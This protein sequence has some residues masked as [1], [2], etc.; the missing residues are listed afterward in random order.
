MMGGLSLKLDLSAD[1]T[2][3]LTLID[4]MLWCS[5]IGPLGVTGLAMSYEIIFGSLLHDDQK[6]AVVESARRLSRRMSS[7]AFVS[8]RPETESLTT[9]NMVSA[10]PGVKTLTE[11]KDEAAADETAAADGSDGGGGAHE[12][13]A[14]DVVHAVHL[15]QLDTSGHRNELRSGVPI[16]N[17]A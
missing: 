12:P 17:S 1:G 2:M 6:A 7:K 14:T 3:S 5:T 15:D 10:P 16:A 4:A 9:R 13:N 11:S 8:V